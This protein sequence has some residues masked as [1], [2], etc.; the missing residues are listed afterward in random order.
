MVHQRALAAET[1]ALEHGNR[2][3]VVHGDMSPDSMQLQLAEA[4]A[5]ECA[6]TL[7]HVAVAPVARVHGVAEHGRA[8]SGIDMLEPAAADEPAA[9]AFTERSEEHTSELQ[10]QSNLVCRL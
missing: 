3:C 6:Q 9:A 1:Q 4:E 8:I 5:H 7:R 10:S 2:P